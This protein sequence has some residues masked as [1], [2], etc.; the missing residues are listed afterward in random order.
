MVMLVNI[1]ENI[2]VSFPVK[3]VLDK[4]R[5]VFVL[6]RPKRPFDIIKAGQPARVVGPSIG[7]FD[8]VAQMTIESINNGREGL[9]VR[10][11]GQA[12]A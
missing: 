8:I 4:D 7:K 10:L 6:A 1:A 12:A 9:C 2:T 11:A 5:Q 3:R